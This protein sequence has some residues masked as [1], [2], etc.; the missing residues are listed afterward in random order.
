MFDYPAVLYSFLTKESE[1][2]IRLAQVVLYQKR[3]P[4]YFYWGSGTQGRKEE[5][6]SF[7][8]DNLGESSTLYTF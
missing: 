2:F 5:N 8:Q 6:L 1:H 3:Y 7:L 4:G